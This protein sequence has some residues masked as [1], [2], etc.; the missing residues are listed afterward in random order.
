MV[1]IVSG[2][3]FMSTDGGQSWKT[4]VTG[5]GINTSYLTTGQINTN[6]IYIMN[7]D[8]PAFR[9]D[10][11][12]LSA[13]FA[14][15]DV[16]GN[17]VSYNFNKYV[18]FDHNG[19][20]GILASDEYVPNNLEE[21]NKKASFALTWDG[22]MLKNNYGDGYVTIDTA[23]DFRINDGLYDR[24]KI[25]ALDFNTQE[26]CWQEVYLD[27]EPVDTLTYYQKAEG[28]SYVKINSPARG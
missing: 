28:D 6:E 14:N 13:Y 7:G 15:K 24:V 21:I 10:E 16:Q 26:D 3:I 25:G 9:W 2:G 5:R 11:K 22:F 18:R 27:G 23:G 8:N 4:G 12:G 17:T 19:I 1:R 20:Y